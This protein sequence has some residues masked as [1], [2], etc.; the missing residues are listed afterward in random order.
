LTNITHSLDLLGE[1][2]TI[3]LP[4]NYLEAMRG[5]GNVIEM[6]LALPPA[7]SASPKLPDGNTLLHLFGPFLFESI[8]IHDQLK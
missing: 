1:F 8:N 7:N 6:F 3:P 2:E 5:L 4:N